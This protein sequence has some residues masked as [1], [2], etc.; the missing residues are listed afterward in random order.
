MSAI[1]LKATETWLHRVIIRIA[2][3]TNE[4]S[5]KD[6]LIIPFF[7]HLGYDRGDPRVVSLEYQVELGKKYPDRADIVLFIQGNPA[8]VVECKAPGKALSRSVSQLSRYYNENETATIGVLTNGREF[9][10]FTDA[11][12]NGAL[13]NEPF[14]TLNLRDIANR[15][16]V[17]KEIDF[18][19]RIHRDTFD[20]EWIAQ[21]AEAQLLRNRLTR[22]LSDQLRNPSPQ[23][24]RYVL[25]QLNIKHVR[26][27]RLDDCAA[28]LQ[29]AFANGLAIEIYNKIRHL[30]SSSHTGDIKNVKTKQNRD[31]IITT[32]RELDIY[33]LCKRRLAHLARLKS[34]ESNIKNILYRDFISKFTV[35]FGKLK[36]GKLFDYI[37]EG[38]KD[39]FIFSLNRGDKVV[40]GLENIDKLLL[41][42]FREKLAAAQDW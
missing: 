28:L 2:D 23:F 38:D 37:D 18:L 12:R 10:F 8:I 35:Y 32:Q 24:C 5:A 15:G 14:L 19:N 3:C 29:D 9:Q 41:E 34:E 42:T 6:I 21:F 13:D 39:K 30:K 7:E 31:R 1:Q 17:E 11:D 22:W 16:L 26:E 20:E 36:K 33:E 25:S 40:Y 27:G 4:S